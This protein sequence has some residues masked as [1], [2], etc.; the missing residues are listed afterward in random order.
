M[1]VQQ[2]QRGKQQA[3]QNDEPRRRGDHAD[4]LDDGRFADLQPGDYVV[5]CFFPQGA[6][7]MD[8]LLEVSDSGEIMP[9]KSTWFEPKL[10]DGMV[11]HVM[12]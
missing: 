8:E 10:A 9:P 2:Q 4:E 5:A 1:I 12:D 6:T 11:N 7:T 3:D